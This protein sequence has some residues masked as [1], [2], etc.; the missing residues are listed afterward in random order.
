LE[1][2]G[3]LDYQVKL[4]GFRIE[5]GEI[6]ARLLEHEAVREAVVTVQ[7][8]SAEDQRLVAHVVPQDASAHQDGNSK[9]LIT[10]LR[11]H[12]SAKLPA[13]MIPG[14]FM[15]LNAMPL[16]ANGKIDRKALPK[17]AYTAGS[18][19]P[20]MPPG[21]TEKTIAEIWK[22]VL[23]IEEAGPEDRFFDLGGHSLLIPQVRTELKNAFGVS[24]PIVEFFQHP[25][26]RALAERI[27]IE[28][29]IHES[30]PAVRKEMPARHSRPAAKE[31][32]SVGMSCRFPAAG[33][34][35]EF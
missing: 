13:Y 2:L 31:F 34:I 26:I 3:R 5:L 16:N 35:D 6:E 9:Q 8:G 15:F 20:G 14:A 12:L 7:Q 29:G 19:E 1:F 18:S 25:T 32:A 10:T 30:K 4:R 33:G 24:L 27:D 22:K 28:R 23:K 11:E 17:A 21:E